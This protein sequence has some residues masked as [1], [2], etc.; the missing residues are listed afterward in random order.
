MEMKKESILTR[1]EHKID[2]VL[3]EIEKYKNIFR[4][5][6]YEQCFKTLKQQFTKLVETNKDYDDE[7]QQETNKN[8][9]IILG[10]EIVEN[11]KTCFKKC[12][13]DFYS[14]Y[15]YAIDENLK[16][17]CYIITYCTQEFLLILYR[18]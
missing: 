15:S 16:S 18:G 6:K 8:D 17:I 5:N 3:N 12:L 9:N 2:N 7:N 4:L 14:N 11:L 10:Y 1:V 13:A